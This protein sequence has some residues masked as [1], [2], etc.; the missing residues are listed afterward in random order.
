MLQHSNSYLDC[1]EQFALIVIACLMWPNPI[2]VDVV[3]LIQIQLVQLQ[4]CQEKLW[5]FW[6]GPGKLGD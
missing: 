3:D 1:M 4:L 2:N 6:M 5:G